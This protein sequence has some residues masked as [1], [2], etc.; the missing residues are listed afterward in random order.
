MKKGGSP[1]FFHQL[2]WAI[3]R[4]QSIWY[5]FL[6]MTP[7]CHHH[8]QSSSWPQ[9]WHAHRRSKRR[10]RWS[11]SGWVP[12]G[13]KLHVSLLYTET[14][15]LNKFFSFLCQHNC[16]VCFHFKKVLSNWECPGETTIYSGLSLVPSRHN[17][18]RSMVWYEVCLG[19]YVVKNP[20]IRSIFL[21]SVYPAYQITIQHH[22]WMHDVP[23]SPP[24]PSR[25]FCWEAPRFWWLSNV[26]LSAKAHPGSNSR[27][28][29]VPWGPFAWLV[30]GLPW[31]SNPFWI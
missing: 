15:I 26:T 11:P 17:L 4:E 5:G 8:H 20:P 9:A 3:L 19:E 6:G 1:N 13:R 10:C 18:V 29:E 23:K 27:L 21:N 25:I 7:P 30:S 24:K 31:I 16:L 14:K 22:S 12:L 2:F 28:S